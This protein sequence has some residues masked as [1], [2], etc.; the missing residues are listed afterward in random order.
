MAFFFAFVA[1]LTVTF[2]ALLVAE[3]GA[4]VT[5]EQVGLTPGASGMM[6]S[7]P[8]CC[9]LALDVAIARNVV[10]FATRTVFENEPLALVVAVATVLVP[11]RSL[12][13]APATPAPPLCSRPVS[14]AEC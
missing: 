11:T 2:T 9:S 8:P 13:V 12:T 6:G 1:F 7:Q 14:L 5:T 3:I 4:V 10:V